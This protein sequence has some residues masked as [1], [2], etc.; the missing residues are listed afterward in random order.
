MVR[1]A[2]PSLDSLLVRFTP[3]T[4]CTADSM[5]EVT[6]ISTS[7]ADAP[8]HADA[9]CSRGSSTSVRVAS[10]R[11]VKETAPPRRTTALVAQTTAGRDVAQ[12]IIGS[13]RGGGRG[14]EGCRR[15][16]PN[17]CYPH[18]RHDASSWGRPLDRDRA[19][20]ARASRRPIATAL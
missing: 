5:G 10:A 19:Q 8:G 9:I 13:R 6:Y 3:R 1:L 18:P 15:G 16:P 2:L 7:S 17:Q 12:R 4:P 14:E 20:L 11:R